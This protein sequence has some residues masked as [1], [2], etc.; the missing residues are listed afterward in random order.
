MG[1]FD[2]RKKQ[3]NRILSPS[4]AL[5]NSRPISKYARERGSKIAASKAAKFVKTVVFVLIFGTLGLGVVGFVGLVAYSLK[6]GEKIDVLA[7]VTS[8]IKSTPLRVLIKEVDTKS[9][10]KS[11]VG[12]AN[13]PEYPG[14]SFVFNEYVTRIGD[15]GF[16]LKEN[17]LPA[18]DAQTLYTFLTGGQS[19]YRL[20]VTS[21][22]EAVQQYYR[23]ELPKR[24]WK[25]ELSVPVTDTEK[26]PGEY[27]TKD[28]KGLHVYTVALDAWYE[29][30]TKE[31]AAQG[32][33][34]K[35]VSYKA[36]QELVAAASGKDLTPDA[37]WKLRYSRDWDVEL[38]KNTIYGVNNVVFTHD[39]SKEKVLIA[40][41]SRYEKNSVD[42]TYKEL[43]TVG[44]QFIST[45]LTTQQTSVTLQGFTKTERIV[46]DGKAVEFSDLKNHAHFMFLLNRK[47]GLFYVIQYF[48]KENP[49]FFEY[50]KSNL[51]L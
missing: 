45:W 39:T 37:V 4:V 11:V 47:N 16:S 26:I 44:S 48:G 6:S 41:L 3:K 2:R 9:E 13:V 43:E 29:T 15:E 40:V 10:I 19:V 31:Q 33:H 32:L 23:A 22:W 21:S 1:L 27:Y 36:K 17:K 50:I 51:K 49:E 14:S 5:H 35:I 38:Q 24:G 7:Q 34:D 12:V 20:P 46:A 25:F 30:I 28:E 42:L 8:M 18:N